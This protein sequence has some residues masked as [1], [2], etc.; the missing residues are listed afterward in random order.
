MTSGPK[1]NSSQGCFR[2]LKDQI[3]FHLG[4]YRL[5]KIWS[6]PAELWQGLWMLYPTVTHI[7]IKPTRG[8]MG[9]RMKIQELS[10]EAQSHHLGDGCTTLWQTWKPLGCT[11]RKSGCYSTELYI[12]F[13]LIMLSRPSFLP[14]KKASHIRALDKL[15]SHPFPR[16][17]MCPWTWKEASIIMKV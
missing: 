3:I 1:Q 14:A 10:E 6:H 9:E 5:M 7:D 12:F 11:L 8:L 15:P 4:H 2:F 17:G 16:K 13:F